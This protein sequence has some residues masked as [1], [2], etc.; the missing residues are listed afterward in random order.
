MGAK[1]KR[2]TFL[3]LIFFGGLFLLLWATAALADFSIG[4]KP[5]MEVYFPNARGVKVGDNVQVLGTNIGV[6][7][8]VEYVATDANLA[9]HPIKLTLELDKPVSLTDEK[10]IKI[11]DASLLG[12]KLVSIDP[13]RSTKKA[14]LPYKGLAPGNALE[15][16]G[17][18]LDHEDNADN[19]AKILRDVAGIVQDL[20]AGEGAVG[21]PVVKAG[22]FFTEAEALAKNINA[23]VDEARKGEGEIG[24][25]VKNIGDFAE[26]ADAL[27][28]DLRN[29]DGLVPRLIRDKTLADNVDVSIANFKTIMDDLAAGRGALGK[30]LRD[31]KTSAQLTLILDEFQKAAGA[32]NSGDGVLA[33]VLHDK[34]LKDRIKNIATNIDSVV[35]DFRAGKGTLG[36][37]FSDPTVYN[38]LERVLNQI[39]RVIEDQREAAPL[40]TFVSIFTGAFQ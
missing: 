18:L 3:G 34:D 9:S 8:D 20:R 13:G 7:L 38:Q 33:A 39:A 5:K 21:R 1:A 31:P 16:L 2:D 24:R 26:K 12:G 6:V 17:K 22:D 35:A 32:I 40:S 19:L 15:A 37:L 36:K 29:G 25:A 27:A 23:A 30:I 4:E 11:A 10:V 28:N 14:E